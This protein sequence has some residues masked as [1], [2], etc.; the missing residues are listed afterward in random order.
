MKNKMMQIT[1]ISLLILGIVSLSLLLKMTPGSVKMAEGATLHSAMAAAAPA[2]PTIN[3]NFSGQVKLN[4]VVTGV[5]SDSL[6]LPA[7]TGQPALGSIDLALQ[8]TQSGNGMSGYVSLDKTLVFT[9][10]HTIAGQTPLQI[11]PYVNG[12]FDGTTLTLQAERV[13][14]V[15][16]G[17][18]LMRQFRLVGTIDADGKTLTGEYRET[19]WGYAPQPITT[20]GAFTLKQPNYNG[21]VAP[22]AASPTPI[23]PAGTPAPGNP[24]P[25]PPAGTPTT[26]NQT[27]YLPLV[28]R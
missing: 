16:G 6:T 28:R 13:S 18:S 4:G 21:A 1:S 27:I 10:E 2:G 5:Y 24:T 19:L 11:G 23:P 12:A 9:V 3:G 7:A 20:I 22:P 25:V 17:Q 26:G 8:L 15:L 14:L